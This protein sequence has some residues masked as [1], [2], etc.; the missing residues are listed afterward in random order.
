[1]RLLPL[2]AA[3]A[4]TPPPSPQKTELRCEP[5]HSIVSAP[6]PPLLHTCTLCT[7]CTHGMLYT[8]YMRK[9]VLC[10]GCV[11]LLSR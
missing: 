3:A 1:M 11:I 4:V 9:P 8:H 2:P 10:R 7:H 6:L 5:P